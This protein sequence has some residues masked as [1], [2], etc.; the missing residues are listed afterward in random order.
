MYVTIK[1]VYMICKDISQLS[2]V[3]DKGNIVLLIQLLS[4]PK[5]VPSKLNVLSVS[6]NNNYYGVIMLE[7]NTAFYAHRLNIQRGIRQS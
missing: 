6:C 2:S 5:E 1:N 7:A 3:D 4:S